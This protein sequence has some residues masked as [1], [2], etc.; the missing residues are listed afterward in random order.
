[1][2]LPLALEEYN[3]DSLGFMAVD[4][5]KKHLLGLTQSKILTGPSVLISPSRDLV[6]TEGRSEYFS[7]H[8][9]PKVFLIILKPIFHQ[10]F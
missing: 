2:Y 8:P 10:A 1:M 9:S 5:I 4:K 6:R 7:L 3:I